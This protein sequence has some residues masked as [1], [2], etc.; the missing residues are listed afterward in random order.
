MEAFELRLWDSRIGRWLTTDPY[1]QFNSPY[2]GMGNNPINGV[3]PDGGLFGRIRAWAHKLFNGGE[4]F[5]N[6]YDQWVWS[7]G[8]GKDSGNM[9]DGFQLDIGEFKNFGYGGLGKVNAEITGFSLYSN[10]DIGIQ[11][12]KDGGTSG[13]TFKGITANL[14][15]TKINYQKENGFWNYSDSFDYIGKNGTVKGR[16]G[17]FSMEKGFDIKGG[18]KY[19]A[20][21][22]VR[23]GVAFSPKASTIGL[24]VPT[25]VKISNYEVGVGSPFTEA[26]V[27]YNVSKKTISNHGGFQE[28]WGTSYNY[29]ILGLGGKFGFR[30]QG[31]FEWKL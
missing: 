21:N 1:G 29:G 4:I 9:T 23:T 20:S 14:F 11:K 17:S 24:L 26:K 6:D 12:V 13:I 8:A 15:T 18:A 7:S 22:W 3:D 19:E 25:D 30:L 16:L 5:K 10:V 28:D 2:L 27:K 31:S